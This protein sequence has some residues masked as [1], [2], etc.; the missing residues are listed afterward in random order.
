[1]NYR[2]RRMPKPRR[3]IPDETKSSLARSRQ[4]AH[5]LLADHTAAMAPLD[6]VAF[7]AGAAAAASDLAGPAI[8]KARDQR[9]TWREISE[10]EGDGDSKEAADRAFIRHR[11]RT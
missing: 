9:F 7:L 1:M 8:T 3:E 5:D 2:H 10:A 6:A 11:R 4:D